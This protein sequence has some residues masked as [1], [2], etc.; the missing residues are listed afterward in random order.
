M[1]A[2][3]TIPCR[4][5]V[6]PQGFYSNSIELSSRWEH[7]SSSLTP[8]L[9]WHTSFILFRNNSICFFALLL[10]PFNVIPSKGKKKSIANGREYLERTLPTHDLKLASDPK[11]RNDA[12]GFCIRKGLSFQSFPPLRRYLRDTQLTLKAHWIYVSKDWIL[13]SLEINSRQNKRCWEKCEVP[14]IMREHILFVR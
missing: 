9:R 5:Q 13:V 4:G 14:S 12:V 7:S 10:T 8:F 1:D 2:V 6:R 11:E 3:E